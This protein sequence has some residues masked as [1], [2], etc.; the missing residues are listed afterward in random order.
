MVSFA[1]SHGTDNIWLQID[2]DSKL[3]NISHFRR[4]VSYA[5]YKTEIGYVRITVSLED[6]LGDFV[7]FPL[8]EGI[9]LRLVDRSTGISLY[10]RGMA[11]QNASREAYLSLLEEIPVLIS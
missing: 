1:S 7:A 9:T 6:L 10:H 5:D 3:G 11:E 2:T 4:L 8:E